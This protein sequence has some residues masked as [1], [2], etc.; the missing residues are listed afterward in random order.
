MYH[1]STACTRLPRTLLGWAGLIPGPVGIAVGVAY[2]QPKALWNETAEARH[3]KHM[4]LR[5][6][7]HFTHLPLAELRITHSQTHLHTSGVVAHWAT[8]YEGLSADCVPVI[9]ASASTVT[10][11][12][13]KERK[14]TDAILF[15]SCWRQSTCMHLSMIMYWNCERNVLQSICENFIKFPT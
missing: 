10:P 5:S 2:I 1:D 11:N 6:L 12:K 14:A 9:P 15:W 3:Y 13:G 4:E 7:L 8:M